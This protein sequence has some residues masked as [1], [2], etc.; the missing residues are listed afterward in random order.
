MFPRFLKWDIREL[1]NSCQW[2]DLSRPVSFKVKVDRLRSFEYERDLMGLDVEVVGGDVTDVVDG[3]PNEEGDND[4]FVKEGNQKTKMGDRQVVGVQAEMRSSK[5][6]GDRI[7]DNV[8]RTAS[9]NGDVPSSGVRSHINVERCDGMEDA[10]SKQARNAIASL[11][12]DNKLKDN[13]IAMLEVEAF[14]LKGENEMQ[15]VHIV[16]GFG[17]VLKM[18]DEKV[19][20]LKKENMEL[21]KQIAVFEDQLVDCDV[22]DVTQAFRTVEVD[23]EIHGVSVASS[24]MRGEGFCDVT[25]LRAVGGC[26]QSDLNLGTNEMMV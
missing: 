8:Q 13:K 16:G 24:E 11:E 15:A 1:L 3:V 19:E 12:N 9:C 20:K 26:S 7:G 5:E 17:C 22:H 23:C 21:R 4:S 2:A 6:H 14:R 18:K 10:I 25:P